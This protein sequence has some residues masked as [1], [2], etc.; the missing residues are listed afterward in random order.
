MAEAT[1]NQLAG[2]IGHASKPPS[3]TLVTG[4]RA[5]LGGLV[6][7]LAR[8]LVTLACG[9]VF[10]LGLADRLS[11]GTVCRDEIFEGVPFTVCRVQAGQD[12]RVFLTAPDGQPYGSF[13]RLAAE[14]ARRG[15]RM[16]FA[17]N[18]GMFHPNQRPVGLY[19][20]NGE[21]HA[22]LMTRAGPGNFGMLPN[23]VFCILPQRFAVVES[24]RFAFA[25]LPCRAATQSGPMLVIDGA[26]HPRFL[27]ESTS[28]LIRNGVG[29]TADG[30][31]A[32]FAIANRPVTF[33]AFARFFR[34]YLGVPQALYLDGSLSRLYARELGRSDW[35]RP[36]GPI[37]ALVEPLPEAEAPKP[38]GE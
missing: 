18:A 38:E 11:A 16:V 33:Y 37:V 19:V 13:A 7:L 21:I 8:G 10:S 1:R 35:G 36:M 12:L 4:K 17:M 28:A 23:G 20:E 29:V 14:L 5:G 31:T 30:Q 9:A 15:E 22:P 3:R 6:A 27:P 26:L 24:Q 2:V 32:F 25:P 34:D